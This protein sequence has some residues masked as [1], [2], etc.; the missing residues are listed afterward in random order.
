MSSLSRDIDAT[1]DEA[2]RQAALRRIKFKLVELK[3]KPTAAKSPLFNKL[4]PEVRKMIYRLLLCNPFLGQTDAVHPR[5]DFGA[6]IS[7]TSTII[8]GS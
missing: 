6:S 3:K 5:V 8:Q 4:P 2:E 1:E 7:Y